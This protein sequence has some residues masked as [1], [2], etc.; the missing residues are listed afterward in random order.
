[1]PAVGYLGQQRSRRQ[2]LRYAARE[3]QRANEPGKLAD[4]RF[5]ASLEATLRQTGT[6]PSRLHLEMTE[7]VV[8]ADAEVDR[9][10]LT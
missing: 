9:N 3:R 8:A 2:I 10:N 1:M 5:V 4:V 7:S 6:D